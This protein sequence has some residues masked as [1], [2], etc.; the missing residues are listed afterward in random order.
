M[1]EMYSKIQLVEN[2]TSVFMETRPRIPELLHGA[3]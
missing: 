1:S 3:Q 2:E